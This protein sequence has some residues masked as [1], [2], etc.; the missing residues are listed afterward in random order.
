MTSSIKPEVHN[1]TTLPEEDRRTAIGNMHK[2]FVKIGRRCDRGQ[3]NTHTD[4]H[5]H[6]N[7]LL[8]YRRR[9]NNWTG[10][11]LLRV[12]CKQKRVLSQREVEI[13]SDVRRAMGESVP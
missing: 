8:P 9:S 10:W 2:K 4:R 11:L 1:I 3:T 13:L 6:H 12:V 5:A 7:T